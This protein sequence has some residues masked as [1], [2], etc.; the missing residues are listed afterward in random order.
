MATRPTRLDPDLERLVE[1][2]RAAIAADRTA[3]PSL[4]SGSHVAELDDYDRS[5]LLEVLR[6]GTY[7][8]DIADVIAADP[9]LAG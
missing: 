9:E 6:D 8:L 4:S 2:A 5:A 1:T 3:W 7:A